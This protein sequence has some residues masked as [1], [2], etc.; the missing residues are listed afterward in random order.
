[1]HK[2][3]QHSQSVAFQPLSPT[4]W[5]HMSASGWVW[6]KKVILKGSCLLWRGMWLEEVAKCGCEHQRKRRKKNA[7][8]TWPDNHGQMKWPSNQYDCI[9]CPQKTGKAIGPIFCWRVDPA[10]DKCRHPV[11][12]S[13]VDKTNQEQIRGFRAIY[14]SSIWAALVCL[15]S[16]RHGSSVA[17]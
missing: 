6:K 4:D 13:S 7:W 10:G 11:L 12:N 3:N 8:T 5:P 17:V 2:W 1:M 14:S 9:M 15:Y 16:S